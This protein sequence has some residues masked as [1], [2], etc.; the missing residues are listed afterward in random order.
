MR[1]WQL[2]DAAVCPHGDTTLPC[3]VTR[4]EGSPSPHISGVHGW[5]RQSSC[6]F[7]VP[8]QALAPRCCGP[9]SRA[10]SGERSG[11]CCLAHGQC[12]VPR[13]M[14]CVPCAMHCAMHCG[15]LCV[16]SM[17]HVP[18]HVPCVVCALSCSLCHLSC[19]LCRVPCSVSHVPYAMRHAV[20]C[21]GHCAALLPQAVCWWCQQMLP[22]R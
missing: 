4:A 2:L 6:G 7:D 8:E 11:P 13:A 21:A 10:Q 22:A 16:C 18:C 3:L 12:W 14:H 5:E 1:V 20:P 15:T 9:E 19:A 17:W